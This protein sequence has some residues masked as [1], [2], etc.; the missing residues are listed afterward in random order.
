MKT[1][2]PPEKAGLKE[3]PSQPAEKT[4]GLLEKRGGKSPSSVREFGHSEG[5]RIAAKERKKDRQRAFLG[6]DKK[7]SVEMTKKKGDAENHIPSAELATEEG[8]RCIR[9]EED[10]V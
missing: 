6:V 2:V 1:T 8:T 7:G 5:K 4:R 3:E 9:R 10:E